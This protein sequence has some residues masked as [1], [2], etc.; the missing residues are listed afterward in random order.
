ARS[1][2]RVN[3]PESSACRQASSLA[4]RGGSHFYA[5][6][7]GGTSRVPAH[8]MIRG[9]SSAL[10][11]TA[12]TRGQIHLRTCSSSLTTLGPTLHRRR[13]R[14]SRRC[15]VPL[16][17]ANLR[18]LIVGAVS[19]HRVQQASQ[20]PG[21]RDDRDLSSAS[22]LNRL[23]PAPKGSDPRVGGPAHPHGGLD[24]QRLDIWVGTSH[25]PAALLLFAGAVLARDQAEIAGDRGATPPPPQ[26]SALI[27]P[28]PNPRAL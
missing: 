1:R 19:P 13:L 7:I 27:E 26:S 15:R 6:S 28:C 2:E 17:R 5:R 18:R 20:P 14:S 16:M 3:R 25:H 22:A 4:A 11:G 23:C 10:F 8:E 24:E 21:Q 9:R 12:L